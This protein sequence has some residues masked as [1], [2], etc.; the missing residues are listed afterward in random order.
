M[1]EE[2]PPETKDNG[3][4]EVCIYGSG[5]DKRQWLLTTTI[6]T[7]ALTAIAKVSALYCKNTLPFV[8]IL[9]RELSAIAA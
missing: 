9:A 6:V 4:E 5:S 2:I 3:A 1:A 8:G 7:M